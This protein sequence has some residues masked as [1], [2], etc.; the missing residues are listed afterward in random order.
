VYIRALHWSLSWARS[1]QSILPHPISLRSTLILS[2]HLW[3]QVKKIL[4]MQFS[5]ISSHFIPLRSKYSP[6][7][8][9][10][11]HPQSSPPY[12]SRFSRKCGSLDVSQIYGPPR[13]V[14]GIALPLPHI[15]MYLLHEYILW[16]N[17]NFKYISRGLCYDI[18]AGWT[19]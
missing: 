6:Q 3:V 2:S 5:P 9:V 1:I 13:P 17:N 19:I 16:T 18:D 15:Q 10:L 14:T 12:V 11:K 7:H 4:I 8:S